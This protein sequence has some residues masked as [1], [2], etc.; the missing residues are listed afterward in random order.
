[1]VMRRTGQAGVLGDC[2]KSEEDPLMADRTALFGC[3][4]AARTALADGPREGAGASPAGR[5]RALPAAAPWR[6]R[7]P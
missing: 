4:H 5:K 2:A 6:A 7:I 1:M 3:T